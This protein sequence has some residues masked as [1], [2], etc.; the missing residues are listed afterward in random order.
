L[1]IESGIV[2]IHDKDYRTVALR[3][4]EFRKEHPD[5]S[6]ITEV[7]EMNTEGVV[8]KATCLD[9]RKQIRSTGLAEENR[10]TGINKT[11]ALE[12]AETSAVGRALAFLGYA[13]S[14]IASAEEIAIA[15]TPITAEQLAELRANVEKYGIDV[16]KFC[17]LLGAA[18][19]PDIPS[20][21]W[22]EVL[23]MVETKRKRARK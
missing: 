18:S 22:P 23:S 2:R 19:L 9:D 14:C 6:V 21:K 12:N 4:K 15:N 7:V 17:Q 10:T 16:P 3:I 5:W 1:N 8:V 11:S 13:G 20:H